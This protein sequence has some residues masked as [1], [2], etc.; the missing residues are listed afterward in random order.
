MFGPSSPGAINLIAGQTNG[1]IPP[2]PA[3]IYSSSH[4]IADGNGG[5]TMIGDIDPYGDVCSTSSETGSMA[6][7]NVGDFLNTANVS[8]GWFEGGFDLTVTNADGTTG[9][10]RA[11][12]PRAFTASESPADYVPH[13]APF[14]YYP[15]TANPT[16]ARPSSV[17]AIGNTLEADGTTKDPANHQYDTHDFFDALKGGNFP[18]VSYLKAPAYQDGH[19]GNSD[20]LDEADFVLQV[21]QAVQNSGDWA[22]TAIV[23]AYDDSDGWYDHQAPPIVN[24]SFST[25]ADALNGDWLLHDG[26][27][28]A[29]RWRRLHRPSA[30]RRRRRCRS[31]TLRLREP[32]PAPRRVALREEELHRSHPDR[33]VLDPPLRRGQLGRRQADP[34][35]RVVRYD[36]R[37][38]REHVLVLIFVS[39]ARCAT[40]ALPFPGAQAP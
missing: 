33:S 20:P 39:D 8:W 5:L 37:H 4:V 22:T 6:G 30:P 17:A 14:Q 13:H 35:R 25:V 38:D 16:H 3:P 1:V 32:H 36:C 11:T 40:R 2:N 27:R 34:G 18:A 29:R 9:C 7:K 23:F 28:A 31:G 26:E 10:N 12:Q 15:S 19:P 21:M 24:P